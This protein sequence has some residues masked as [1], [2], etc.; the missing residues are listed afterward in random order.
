MAC[1]GEKVPT[2]PQKQP[3]II[4][5]HGGSPVQVDAAE[6]GVRKNGTVEVLKGMTLSD[7]PARTIG[8]AF[9]GYSHFTS[10]E[11]KETRTASRK[12]YID[13]YGTRRSPVFSLDPK[14]RQNYSQG[15]IIKFVINPDGRFFVA[16]ISKVDIMSDGKEYAVPLNDHKKILDAIYENTAISF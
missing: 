16:M 1:S 10:R 3:R 12:I 5:G 4:T 11:W 8:E 13:F 14:I 2:T 15:V 6:S 7:Y 9:E